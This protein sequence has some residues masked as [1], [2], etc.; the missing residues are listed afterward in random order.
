[1]Q[2]R[3]AFSPVLCTW[4]PRAIRCEKPEPPPA[5]ASIGALGCLVI[6]ASGRRFDSECVG[7]HEHPE[8]AA[9]AE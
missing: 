5:W 6:F 2:M 7:D 9:V 3:D 1:V 4:H 8:S